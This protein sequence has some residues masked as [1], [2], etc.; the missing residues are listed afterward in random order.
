MPSR[1]KTR[2]RNSSSTKACAKSIRLITKKP[3]V[4]SSMLPNLILNSPWLTGALPKLLV[5]ITTIPPIR[6]ATSKRTKQSQ[7]RLLMPLPPRLVT[8]LISKLWPNVFPP[9]P[10]L[11]SR[12]HPPPLATR[13]FLPSASATSAGPRSSCISRLARLWSSADRRASLSFLPSSPEVPLRPP[14]T[15][16]DH[17]AWQKIHFPPL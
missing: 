11:T 15:T 6:F 5:L 3:L 1:R 17:P 13:I 7:R 2:T 14:D 12:R 8:R 10:G 9:T 4:R 16:S